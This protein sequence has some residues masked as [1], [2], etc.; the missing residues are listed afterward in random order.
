MTS[1]KPPHPTH[2]CRIF[3]HLFTT[4][5]ALIITYALAREEDARRREALA[6]L[7]RAKTVFFSSISHEFRTPLTL[8]LGPLEVRPL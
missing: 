1:T 6:E 3:L 2:G 7:A 5:V 8:M 4:N